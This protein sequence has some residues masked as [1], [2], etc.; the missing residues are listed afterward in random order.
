MLHRIVVAG[1]ISLKVCCFCNHFS[2]CF[3]FHH[4]EAQINMR[5]KLIPAGSRCYVVD[6]WTDH[7][8]GL[9]LTKYPISFPV[10]ERGC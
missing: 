3:L 10:K 1:S 2:E 7:A 5:N 6:Q 4:E 9:I 8:D